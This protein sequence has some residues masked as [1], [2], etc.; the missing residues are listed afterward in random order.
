[1]LDLQVKIC[2]Q[3]RKAVNFEIG[4]YCE[5]CIDNG[6]LASFTV[7]KLEY[8]P[9][10]GTCLYTGNLERA[11]ECAQTAVKLGY[12]VEIYHGN[13]LFWQSIGAVNVL[14]AVAEHLE[15]EGYPVRIDDYG[16]YWVTNPWRPEWSKEEIMPTIGLL[17][18]SDRVFYSRQ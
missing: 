18:K 1:M 16:R 14:K 8:T 7:E 9:G 4:G 15:S 5:E 11:L 12:D 6:A 13:M 10:E 2:A 17:A 3:C